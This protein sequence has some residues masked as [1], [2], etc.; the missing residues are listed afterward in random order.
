VVEHE[1]GYRAQQ[2]RPV[3]LLE[4]YGAR[5][6][7]DVYGVPLLSA[8]ELVVFAAGLTYDVGELG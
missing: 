5:R 2:A 7:A 4:G 3:A 6:V 8:D 1:T